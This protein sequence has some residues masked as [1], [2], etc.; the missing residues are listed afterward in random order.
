MAIRVA[1]LNVELVVRVRGRRLVCGNHQPETQRYGLHIGNRDV[2][3]QLF[4]MSGASPA[5]PCKGSATVSGDAFLFIGVNVVNGARPSSNPLLEPRVHKQLCRIDGGRRRGSGGWSRARS[6]T[7]TRRRRAV[8]ENKFEDGMQLD[9]VD[10]AACLKV[11]PVV[12][13]DPSYR[14]R[15]A[16]EIRIMSRAIRESCLDRT[17][18]V[19]D[20]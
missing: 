12:E 16:A 3:V 13:R 5:H 10:R 7:R 6:R 19:A 8:V 1:N 18:Y 20:L 17:S 11:R 14:H 4:A 2:L 9:T 15:Y